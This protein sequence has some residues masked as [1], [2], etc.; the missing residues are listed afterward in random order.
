MDARC[1]ITTLV[2]EKKIIIDYTLISKGVFK[3]G[4]GVQGL[5]PPPEIFRL[6][7]EK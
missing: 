5:H 6:F 7:F 1:G 3:W 2:L 4:G